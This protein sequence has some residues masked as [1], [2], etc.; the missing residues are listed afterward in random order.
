M[1]VSNRRAILGNSLQAPLA[2]C[3][4]ADTHAVSHGGRRKGA[5]RG[6]PQWKGWQTCYILKPHGTVG[7]GVALIPEQLNLFI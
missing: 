4:S 2:M 5:H 6:N 3:A 1:H 7:E